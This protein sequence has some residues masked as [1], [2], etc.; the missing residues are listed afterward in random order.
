[1]SVASNG[2]KPVETPETHLERLTTL[3]EQGEWEA[4]VEAAG[5]DLE[6]LPDRAQ[7]SLL[8]G[9]GMAQTG[10]MEAARA[11]IEQAEEWGCDRE[12]MARILL[13]GALVNL[14]RMAIID[15]AGEEAEVCFSQAAEIAQP[16]ADPE[17]L[18]KTS[19]MR[20]QARLGFLEDAAKLL[21]DTVT[22]WPPQGRLTEAMRL[23]RLEAFAESL[24]ASRQQ[25]GG[26]GAEVASALQSYIAQAIEA[27]LATP[28]FY[29]TL[30]VYEKNM[31]QVEC[32]HLYF[33]LSEHFRTHKDRN[34]ALDCLAEVEE[35]LPAEEEGLRARLITLY[36]QLNEPKLA[37]RVALEGQISRSTATLSE[38]NVSRLRQ[39]LFDLGSIEGEHGHS[40]LLAYFEANPVA[41]V[42]GRQR[43]LIEVGTTR[44]RVPGQGS[45][46]KL[47]QFCARND[48][49]LITV[50]MDPRNSLLARRS[51]S[52]LGWPFEAV[53]S[54]GEDYLADYKGEIDYAFLDAY[55]FDHGKHSELRQS[56][57]E[58]FLNSRIDEEECHK[59]HLKCAKALQ[60][61]LAP[62]GLICIDD[63]WLD[64]TG[65]W[66]AKGALAVPYL[67]ENDFEIVESRN[68]AVL[69]KRAG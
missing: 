22:N 20:E 27:S 61:K 44:E 9:A 31:T 37:L 58:A 11:A 35:H 19:N 15:G 48:M 33:A 52:Q 39:T 8:I 28:H 50:D 63:T 49:Q 3:W 5:M 10:D 34:M 42:E 47:G 36:M 54:P 68:R 51:F 1:M 7:L 67:L 55:D 17:A 41:Q 2:S 60:E 53:T 66:T 46:L 13:S 62:D 32:C 16:E 59:M 14:G 6:T 43:V 25:F 64:E 65:N 26:E 38:T 56:R 12:Q 30:A 57:Y 4:L 18:G 23:E 45:T 69:M 40:L 24:G 29:E 21:Q